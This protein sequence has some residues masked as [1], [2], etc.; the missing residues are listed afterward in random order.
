MLVDLLTLRANPAYLA[1]DLQPALTALFILLKVVNY[2]H[3]EDCR[4]N[5]LPSYL[6]P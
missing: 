1:P 6:W 4:S 2:G 5:Q 3:A